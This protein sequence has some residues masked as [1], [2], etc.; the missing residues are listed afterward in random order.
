MLKDEQAKKGRPLDDG[1]A[2]FVRSA[3]PSSIIRRTS[4]MEE[5][6]NLIVATASPLKSGT[7]EVGL[8]VDGGIVDTIA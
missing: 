1:A 6:G 5:V 2:D 4:S 8:R 3:R 7:T